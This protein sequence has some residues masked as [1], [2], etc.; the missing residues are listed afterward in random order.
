MIQCTS[1]SEYSLLTRKEVAE[2]LNVHPGSVKRYQLQGELPAI[3]I[4]SRVVRYRREDVER[5]ITG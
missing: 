1:A 5:F 2:Y 4:N 3:L